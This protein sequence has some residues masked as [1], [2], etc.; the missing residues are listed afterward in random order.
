MS[1]TN[2]S[3]SHTDSMINT[4]ITSAAM[5]I[6]EPENIPQKAKLYEL[7]AMIEKEFDTL[8]ME[9][10]ALRQRLDAQNTGNEALDSPNIPGL[11]NSSEYMRD[12]A[13]GIKK[14][15][16]MRNKWK[17]AFRG[18]PGRLV[19][20][21]KVGTGNT[22]L[23]KARYMRNF[24]GHTDA[25]WDLATIS[26]SSINAI[27]S[28]SAD[29][30]AKIWNADTGRCL[31]S[32]TGHG[33]SVNSVAIYPENNADELIVLTASGDRSAHLWKT[34]HLSTGIPPAASSEDDL[35]VASDKEETDEQLPNI[36]VVI[37][38]PL[39]RFTGHTN[40]VIAADW[41]D[42]KEQIVTASWD[43]TANI[44]DTENGK[45]L[46]TLNGHDQKLTHCSTHNS[47]K[48]VATAS[49]DYTF[50]LWD[51]RETIQSVAVFQGHNDAVTSVVFSST[52]HIISGS[53]DRT[54][55]VW[56]LRNMRSPIS[57]LRLDS[58]VNRLAV[59]Q[60]QN[61][62]AIPHDNRHIAVF[63]LRGM[64]ALTRLPRTNDRVSF[65]IGERS[66][67]IIS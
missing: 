56:D 5:D 35:D 45:I 30:T 7:F 14:Q 36:P 12:L 37:R 29:Q 43:H 67:N 19:T 13:K 42:G 2:R 16:Q 4:T 47:R 3:R 57:A 33:G 63:D 49:K 51:F 52:H 27:A 39:I 40:A 15:N 6:I 64:R 8:Y 55:K 11:T 22:E 65:F 59:H 24:I 1:S 23:S 32:Y 31:L 25:V 66:I 60:Q 44:Y 41:I 9:N 50:R 26:N 17:T 61:L 18:P 48:L 20:S 28:A 34:N 10:Y 58:A 38:Q 62:V 21:L 53:D 46:N 54:V